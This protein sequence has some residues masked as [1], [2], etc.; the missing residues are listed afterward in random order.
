LARVVLGSK[1]ATA[2]SHGPRTP[3]VCDMWRGRS[4]DLG[5]RVAASIVLGY[6]VVERHHPEGEPDDGR[7]NPGKVVSASRP[8]LSG[9]ASHVMEDA[10]VTEMAEAYGEASR[11]YDELLARC[12]GPGQRPSDDELK[13]ALDKREAAESVW[14]EAYNASLRNKFRNQFRT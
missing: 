2:S 3:R 13:A 5:S 1:H 6:G 8:V 10:P 14:L 11:A 7:Q 12:Q 4:G 9:V